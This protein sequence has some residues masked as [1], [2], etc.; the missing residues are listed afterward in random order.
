MIGKLLAGIL[1]VSSA[2]AGEPAPVL[3][4]AERAHLQ[5]ALDYMNMTPSDLT[6]EKD[7][8]KP[9]LVLKRNRDMLHDPLMLP[10]LADEVLSATMQDDPAVTWALARDLLELPPRTTNPAPEIV[11]SATN[12][13]WKALDPAMGEMLAGFVDRKSVV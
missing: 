8:S 7:V 6:F 1:L 11:F 10:S 13:A 12:E 4:P 3:G 5:N 2:F 9:K